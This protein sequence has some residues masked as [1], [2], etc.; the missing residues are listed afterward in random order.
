MVN[1][2]CLNLFLLMRG[3]LIFNNNQQNTVITILS[4]LEVLKV[5]NNFLLLFEDFF[6]KNYKVAPIQPTGVPLDSLKHIATVF[7]TPPG[8]DFKI[9]GGTVSLCSI[10]K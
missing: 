3:T 7:S 9:H 2:K 10:Y 6:K 5:S 8:G 4:S 1:E